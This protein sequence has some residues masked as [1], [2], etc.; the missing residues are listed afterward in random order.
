MLEPF[1]VNPP[2]RRRKLVV[3]GANHPKKRRRNNPFLGKGFMAQ[4]PAGASPK[5][6]SVM[7]KAS[8]FRKAGLS[9]KSALKKAWRL[10]PMSKHRKKRRNP[11]VLGS[12]PRRRKSYKRRNP[13]VLGSNPRRRSF[14]RF[15][16]IGPLKALPLPT[17]K[18]MLA[19]G[20]GSLAAGFVVPRVLI[21][22][23]F[24][25]QK[26]IVRA[27]SRIA[28]VAGLG[29]A[30]KKVAP[31]QAVVFTYGAV[32]NQFNPTIND[33]LSAA[34]VQFQLGDMGEEEVQMYYG[35]ENAALPAP[36][37]SGTAM[38]YGMNDAVVG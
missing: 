26:P 6:K 24:L 12:N 2:I 17:V 4:K 30:A 32:A 22:V 20:A 33:L 18:N 36:D 5:L 31:A 16:P 37:Q 25:G 28:I 21:M 1:L 11:V 14:R 29:F 38:Y 23:P 7:Q 8:V 9:A 34:N 15:N 35:G 13:V 19:L 3:F 27:L 10:N